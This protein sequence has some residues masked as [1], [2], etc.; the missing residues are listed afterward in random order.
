MANCWQLESESCEMLEIWI[1]K[2]KG[3][4]KNI[5]SVSWA[6]AVNKT[7]RALF[8]SLNFSKLESESFNQFSKKNLLHKACVEQN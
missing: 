6:L 4:G 1:I 8:P 2:W 7:K 5:L 3:K